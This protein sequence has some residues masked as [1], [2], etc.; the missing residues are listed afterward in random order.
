[1]NNWAQYGSK[2]DNIIIHLNNGKD[3]TIEFI[4]SAV[5]GDDPYELRDMVLYDCIKAAEKEPQV[6]RLLKLKLAGL[7]NLHVQN[8]SYMILLLKHFLSISAK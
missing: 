3:P 2:V 5:D 6:K 8:T 7:S 4:P 1:M